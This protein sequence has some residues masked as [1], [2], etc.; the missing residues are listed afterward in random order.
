VNSPTGVS[1]VLVEYAADGSELAELTYGLRLIGQDRGGVESYHLIDAND[2]VRLL[3]NAAGEVTDE[4]TYTA[5]GQSLEAS[6]TTENPYRFAGE[7]FGATENL[8]FFRARSY[9]SETG[10]FISRDPFQGV[11]DEPITRHRYLYAN[12]NPVSFRDPTGL[13]SIA[14]L[15]TASSILSSIQGSYTSALSNTL[16]A[17]NRIANDF[18]L[19][20]TKG[21]ELVFD[22]LSNGFFS[23]GLFNILNDSNT[24]ISN[25]FKLIS[26]SAAQNLTNFGFSLFSPATT[27]RGAFRGLEF[28]FNLAGIVGAAVTGGGPSAVVPSLPQLGPL[29]NLASGA[30]AVTETAVGGGNITDQLVGQTS[31]LIVSVVN[32]FTQ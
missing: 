32:A 2:N 4:Y 14:E 30:A 18:I 9:D 7:R 15:G 17:A 24:T 29:A 12:G 20:G 16:I 21:R 8:G 11:L 31:G 6:G 23:P 28:D 27:I 13:F 22:A 10:R 19:V 5:F 3:T 25:G 26:Q 1:Q